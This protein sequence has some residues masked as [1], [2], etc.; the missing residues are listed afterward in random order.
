MPGLAAT[1]ALTVTPEATETPGTMAMEIIDDNSMDQS[2]PPVEAQAQY[3]AEGNG[4]RWI[5][6]NRALEE[7]RIT[8]AIHVC[9]GYARDGRS[10]P[11]S[12]EFLP[13][14][15]DSIADQ[16]SIE[17]AQ[18]KLD[19]GILRDLSG[20]T[21]LL[22]VIDLGDENIEG[23]ETVASRIRD[24]LRH[25]DAQRL[26]PAPDCGMKYLTRET[27]FGKLKALSDGAAIVRRELQ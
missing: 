10:K 27:A 20:K 1:E 21:I 9:F 19:L 24:G 6:V 17:A 3:P 16:I 15:G 13:Q 11:S 22:G 18:P 14:L 8:K 26:I 2:V 4:E 23:P 5:D 7:L 25:L 12:Y